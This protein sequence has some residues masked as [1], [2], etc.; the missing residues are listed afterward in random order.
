MC[1]ECWKEAGSPAILNEKTRAAAA[2]IDAVYAFDDECGTGGHL[3]CQLEDWN[4]EDRFFEAGDREAIVNGFYCSGSPNW[5]NLPYSDGARKAQL[6]CFDALAAMTQPERESALAFS[7]GYFD[8]PEAEPRDRMAEVVFYIE[9]DGQTLPVTRA[10]QYEALAKVMRE[11]YEPLSP[12]VRQ[13]V[14]RGDPKAIYEALYPRAGVK[15][16]A[17]KLARYGLNDIIDSRSTAAESEKD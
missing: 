13:G 15:A 6:D 7:Y 4:L 9:M 16:A 10:M 17:E 12:D 2:L 11:A 8:D 5:E 3:H 1:D 14:A